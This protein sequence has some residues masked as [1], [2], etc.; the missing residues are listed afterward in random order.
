M[1]DIYV[2]RSDCDDFTNFGLVG[3]LT[4]TSCVFEEEANGM[5]EITMK[6][7]IDDWGRYTQLV[8]NNL[9]MVA[10]PVRT[11]PGIKGGRIVT[12]VER[13]TVRSA[14]TTTTEQRTLYKKNTGNGKIKVL[15]EGTY[16]TV[17]DKADEGRYKVTC[18]YGTG[19]MEADGLDF[20]I[21]QKIADKSQSIESVQPAW[22][23][24][25]QVFRIYNVEK[26]IDSIT[27]SAR[28]IS[29]DLLYNLTTFKNTGE[30]T[31]MAA[32][33]GIMGTNGECVA[34][35]E[36]NAYTNL[37]TVRTGVDWTRTNP[38]DALLNPET[39]LT[40]LY[41]ASLV[42]DNW[43]LYVL[44]D[45]GL[46]RGVTVEYGKNMTG[47]KYT[48]S[49]ENVV[50]R[51]VPVGETK[52]GEPLLLDGNAPWVDSKHIKDYP[53]VYVQELQC[54]NCKV[55]ENKVT[56]DIAWA[57]MKE[58]ANAVFEA[59]GD[60][61]SVEMS[62]DFINLG[63]TEEFKQY[64]NLERLFLWDYVLVR[65]KL[66]DID[67]TSRIVSIQWDCLLDR[68]NS[69]EIGSVGKTLA[70]S[71]IT[72]WQIP[73]GFSGSKIASGT[74]SG[75]ALKENIISARH[76]QTDSINADAI[77]ANAITAKKLAA[78]SIEAR[79]LAAH[80]VDA[81]TIEAVTAKLKNVVANNITAD[82]LSAALAD[83]V[84][85]NAKIGSFDTADVM[86]LLA[87]A[88]TLK[89]GN[90]ESMYITNLAVTSANIMSAILGDLV[91]KQVNKDD[92]T[93]EYYRIY[94]D[95]S[96]TIQT[97]K[98]TVT[99]ENGFES[100]ETEAGRKIV[101]TSA[102]I[103]DVSG[104][105]LNYNTGH[106]ANLITSTLE[107][108]YISATEALLGSATIPKLNTT[109]I[110]A[111]GNS[112]TL[113]ANETIRVIVGDLEEAKEAATTAQTEATTAGDKAVEAGE[114]AVEAVEEIGK[115]PIFTDFEKEAVYIRDANG[116]STLKLN[117]GSVSIGTVDGDGRGYSQLAADY[118][119][120]GN[121]QLRKT[122]DGG[123]AF[124]MV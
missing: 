8:C 122:A 78:E 41:G 46:N 42:R 26:G 65:H 104:E 2:Y 12:S 27:V 24:K 5:S 76:V 50:T 123:M 99:D 35:H 57:R 96:G 33:N 63:D 34:P 102:V 94:I 44:H 107:T 13:W 87:S 32:L 3:A 56:N 61:P 81:Q 51:I 45:P 120:F 17:V 77:Q 14:S 113:S 52:D 85:M 29:Y 75:G 109:A 112:M 38:I 86:N 18:E 111:I 6:H 53:V 21:A 15:P 84:S 59:G 119:M 19:W 82:E 36:F 47:I 64:K 108:G 20:V 121:Y 89:E 11:M 100:D 23:V 70:N 106:F 43:E 66:L 62:V 1:A 124:K 54:E 9:L 71:G 115:L 22:T 16:V 98:V 48:E 88:L 37:L 116:A 95:E 90:A 83:I 31:C 58:Q 80:A 117:S 105:T 25:P 91:F 49:F 79:H 114:K 118:V 7:P 73:T 101:E 68:M 30:V 72:K 40:A 55:G 28:H 93:A 103:N 110:N 74:V 39:G 60:L 97:E 4:P 69:M 92:G 10:V 67:V